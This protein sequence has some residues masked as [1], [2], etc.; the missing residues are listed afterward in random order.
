MFWRFS[1]LE[2]GVC[3]VSAPDSRSV[4]PHR[5]HSAASRCNFRRI[6]HLQPEAG[7]H[8]STP[9]AASSRVSALCDFA[10]SLFWANAYLPYKAT[11]VTH[12]PRYRR[13]CHFAHITNMV[14]PGSK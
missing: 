3:K 14:V 1:R 11:G 6:E 12:P 10:T 9:A 2:L 7:A 8:W 5:R 4:C 13:S